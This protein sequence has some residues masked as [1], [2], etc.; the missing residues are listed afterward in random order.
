MRKLFTIFLS[1]FSSSLGTCQGLE[2]PPTPTE[3]SIVDYHGHL[4][5]D[6][7]M[8]LENGDDS[9]VQSWDKEQTRFTQD[10]QSHN[11]LLPHLQNRFKELLSSEYSYPVQLGEDERQLICYQDP[12]DHAPVFYVQ[13]HPNA[14]L[15]L[16]L[17]VNSWEG[18]HTIEDFHPSPNGDIVAFLVCEGG[19]ESPQI[20]LMNTRT[21]QPLT[22]T[23]HGT[24]HRNLC[25]TPDS[26]SFYYSAC[27]HK[28]EVREGD[29]YF[30]E[31]VYFHTLGSSYSKDFVIYQPPSEEDKDWMVVHMTEHEENILFILYRTDSLARQMQKAFFQPM[32]Q[33]HHPIEL[34]WEMKADEPFCQPQ[35][36][37]SN[38][39]FITDDH[40]DNRRLIKKQWGFLSFEVIPEKEYYLQSVQGFNGCLAVTYL[41]NGHKEIHLYSTFGKFIKKIPLPGPGEATL[42]GD[43]E[44]DQAYLFYS[45]LTDPGSIY[46]YHDESNS[47]TILNRAEIPGYHPQDYTTESITVTSKDGTEV[48]VHIA[49]KKEAEKQAGFIT[50]YG[51]FGLS[52]PASFRPSNLPWLESGN[53]VA[54]AHIRGGGEYGER[55]HQEATREKKQNCFDDFIAASEFLTQHYCEPHRLAMWGGSNGGLLAGAITTQ[56]PDLYGAVVSAVPVLDMLRYLDFRYGIFWKGEYGDSNDPLQFP[57]LYHYSPYHNIVEGI[58]YPSLLLTTGLNDRRVDPMHARKMAAMIQQADPHGLP[59]L[60]DVDPQGGHTFHSTLNCAERSAYETSFLMNEVHVQLPSQRKSLNRNLRKQLFLQSLSKQQNAENYK[61]IIQIQN[62]IRK[63]KK[64]EE[65]IRKLQTLP[66]L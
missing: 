48:P 61:E 65:K 5:D 39:Y 8:W 10:Y 21:L 36:I 23:V 16:L 41:V 31:N 9:R 6:P 47:L 15:Q 50:A 53:V 40:A 30:W 27:P 57:F 55:W 14:E 43:W 44:S 34:K 52:E 7:Y 1:L 62:K 66:R 29:E 4:V 45:S 22:D 63:I 60:I 17:N 25:W 42:I 38:L 59:H 33:P 13:E 2:Y 11:P 18:V 12:E 20:H 24:C 46:S 58:S 37:G 51:G 49:Y 56:R 26:S 54:L 32:G 35:K 19:N 28:G 64:Q 3:S